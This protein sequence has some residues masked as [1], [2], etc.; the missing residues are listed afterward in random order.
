MPNIKVI[1]FYFSSYKH[2]PFR[3]AGQ[4]LF[5]KFSLVFSNHC[6]FKF[7]SKFK[8][9][10][11]LCLIFAVCWQSTDVEYGT[12]SVF[13]PIRIPKKKP[14]SRAGEKGAFLFSLIIYI[15]SFAKM[16]SHSWKKLQ[17]T[18]STSRSLADLFQKKRLR[19]RLQAFSSF[20]HS[21][22]VSRFAS[23][24]LLQWI[25]NYHYF[26]AFFRFLD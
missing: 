22:L 19:Q 11:G 9:L 20:L 4:A 14:L 1:R 23:D 2:N 24:H 13:W 7:Y 26:L 5:V 16:L 18:K 3:F 15:S 17:P 12:T 25:Y 10:A 21:H 6:N 8:Q